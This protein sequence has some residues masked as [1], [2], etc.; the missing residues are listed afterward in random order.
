MLKGAGGGASALKGLGGLAVGGA[1]VRSGPRACALKLPL[2][3][4][5]PGPAC[6]R[7]PAAGR[8]AKEQGTSA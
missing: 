5:Q 7:C 8:V 3:A 2:R 4:G 6:A 1:L